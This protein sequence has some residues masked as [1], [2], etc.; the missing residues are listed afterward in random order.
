[1]RRTLLTIG[2]VLLLAAGWAPVVNPQALPDLELPVLGGKSTPVEQWAGQPTL[3][4]EAPIQQPALREGSAGATTSASSGVG[5]PAADPQTKFVTRV[6]NS[7]NMGPLAIRDAAQDYFHDVGY[8]IPAASPQRDDFEENASISYSYT[9]G[10]VDNDGVDDVAIDQYCVDWDACYYSTG[11][12]LIPSLDLEG[13]RRCG[14]PHRLQIIG[15]ESG[16]RIWMR[17]MGMQ[18]NSLELSDPH[19]SLYCPL[20]FVVGTVTGPDGAAAFVVYRYSVVGTCVWRECFG[21]IENH[22]YLLGAVNQTIFWNI[23]VN[24]WYAFTDAIAS[25]RDFFVNPIIQVPPTIGVKFIANTTQE[26]LFLQSVGFDV[27]GMV[28][29]CVITCIPPG[30]TMPP[31]VLDWYQPTEWAAKIE[32]AT[33][34]EAW[35][36]D[37]FL[38]RNDRS[39]VPRALQVPPLPYEYWDPFTQEPFYKSITYWEYQPCCFDQDGDDIPDLPFTTLEWSTTPSTNTQGPFT[40]ASSLRVHTGNAGNVLFDIFLDPKAVRFL[41]EEYYAGT[42]LQVSLEAVGDVNNDGKD[43]ILVHLAYLQEDYK[44]VIGVINGADGKELWRKVAKR[45][46][47]TFTIGDANADGGQDI[48]VFEWFGWEHSRYGYYDYSNVTN[49]PLH[50]LNGADGTN[51]WS[52]VTFNA[53]IDMEFLYTSLKINGIPDLDGDGVGD[54]QIDDPVFLPDLTVIHRQAFLSG[55]SGN[56]LFQYPTVGTFAIPALIGDATGDGGD[57]L[58]MISGDIND[59]WITVINGTSGEAAWSR[60][61]M[62]VRASDY[63]FATPLLRFH[64]LNIQNQSAVRPFMNFQLEI[65]SYAYFFLPISTTHPML[66]AYEGGNGTLYWSLPEFWDVRLSVIV[67]GA[68]P[69]TKAFHQA[70]AEAAKPSALVTNTTTAFV[71]FGPGTLAFIVASVLGYAVTAWRRTKL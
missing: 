1:M 13:P 70:V 23:T 7:P 18:N 5:F 12:N 32:I 14:T 21:Q 43:D 52:S 64:S 27:T 37:T 66:A 69:A 35:H 31:V 24:G 40:L 58:A 50:V 30:T 39:V 36:Q 20:E 26:A 71:R 55:A 29:P 68:T 45:D 49:V 47:R 60:R 4:D 48:L 11:G 16:E 57:D 65:V 53:P 46:L 9:V 25:G 59:L 10:D 19:F 38:P 8:R 63:T 28:I 51:I 34:E 61:V 56:R 44:H 17:D 41:N 22:I 67:E 6:L 42:A 54:V 3:T 2:V 62:T 15:G 33:G